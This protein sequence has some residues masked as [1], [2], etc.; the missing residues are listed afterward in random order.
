MSK[1][2]K[3]RATKKKRPVEEAVGKIAA[4]MERSAKSLPEP[5]RSAMLR[6][7]REIAAATIAQSQPAA[8]KQ[9]PVPPGGASGRPRKT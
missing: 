3:Q 9:K 1:P 2:K 7:I 5:E 4:M 8:L 6:K